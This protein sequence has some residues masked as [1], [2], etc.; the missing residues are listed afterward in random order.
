[1][2]V[3]NSVIPT[4]EQIESLA[5]ESVTGPIYMVNLLKFKDQAEY[6]D[7]RASELTGRQA[8]QL[9]GREVVAHLAK[10]GGTLVFGGDVTQLLLGTVEELWDEIA[11]AKYPNRQAMLQMIMDP[12]YQ[13]SA[14][15]RAAGL[16]GQ[17]NIETVAPGG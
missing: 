14:V 1:M 17:L 9:Y 2:H 3:E 15:H 5:D 6:P 8:Y 4:R 7:G 16:Q 12:D 13:A 11:I 10:V